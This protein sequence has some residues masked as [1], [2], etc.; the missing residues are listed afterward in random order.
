MDDFIKDLEKFLARTE[1]YI[2]DT[3]ETDQNA[4]A[5]WLQAFFGSIEASTKALEDL[6]AGVA[7]FEKSMKAKEHHFNKETLN[8]CI[9]CLLRSDLL[10]DE[11]RGVL[12]AIQKD[13][14][15]RSDVIDDLNM[16]MDTLDRWAWPLEGVVAEQRREQGTK[17]RFF[18]DENIMD[19]ILLRYIGVKW[20]VEIFKRLTAFAKAH[21]WLSPVNTVSKEDRTKRERFLGPVK[22]HASGV[23]GQR[24]ETYEADFFLCQLLRHEKEVDPRYDII[25][26]DYYEEEEDEDNG[27]KTRKSV[28]ELKH[29]LLQLLNVEV[30]VGKQLSDEVTVLQ[31]D[32]KSFGPSIPHSTI[33][34]VLTFFGV[35]EFWTNFFRTALA[36]PIFFKEDGQNAEIRIRKRGTQMSSPPADLAS[37][38]SLFAWI[39][40][41]NMYGVQR[42]TSM[43]GGDH[44]CNCFGAQHVTLMQE[45]FLMVNE[46]VFNDDTNLPSK[47]RKEIKRRFPSF[48][49][50]ILDSFIF[51]PEAVGG[52]GV[53]NP[54]VTLSQL[55]GRLVA[56]PEEI[57]HHFRQAEIDAYHEARKSYEHRQN[58]GSA[59][60]KG[61]FP[62]S[63]FF[64][65]NEFTLSRDQLSLGFLEASQALLRQ[66]KPD[67]VK[68]SE[69]VDEVLDESR[70]VQ[71]PHS[72]W[73]LEQYKDEM[74][75]HFGGLDLVQTKLLPMGMIRMARERRI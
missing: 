35:S 44:P 51:L 23:Q 16:R 7:D 66:P 55:E 68:I 38:K 31:S 56:K 43:L 18:H 36:V 32:F 28:A 21:P 26:R 49:A 3:V 6:R 72:Q 41:W 4:I 22:N 19:A 48:G 47:L 42:F 64:S 10:T 70:G 30:S 37:C 40:V 11:K 67:G 14:D 53:M 33:V 60:R 1:G 29:S 17:W 46:K 39:R 62:R 20:S 61:T 50:D 8:W 69:E 58:F 52:L 54:F 74:I 34:A 2:F 24:L 63:G 5:D 27:I 75:E 59:P 12:T 45:F 25:Y 13:D 15:A 9:W 71:G 65:F 57:M 73:L